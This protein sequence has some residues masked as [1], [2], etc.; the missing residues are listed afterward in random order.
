VIGVL[1]R[2]QLGNHM[3]QYAAARCIAERLGSELVLVSFER[4]NG[5]SSVLRPRFGPLIDGFP[6][7]DVNVWTSGLHRLRPVSTAA[8]RRLVNRLLPLRFSLPNKIGSGN[9]DDRDIEDFFAVTAG[10]LLDGYFQSERF[11]SHR[12]DDVRQWFQPSRAIAERATALTAGVPGG[13]QGALAVHV[14]LGD[15]KEQALWHDDRAYPWVLGREFYARALEQFPP[16]IPLALFSDEPALAARIL[17]RKPTWVASD[18]GPVETLIALSRF[19][20]LVVA[21]SS[22]SWWAGWLGDPGKKVVAPEYHIGRNAGLWC[23][24]GIRTEGWIYV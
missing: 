2:G 16:D 8:H 11:F 22:F 14:R 6:R 4:G 9:L 1:L 24:A 18:A 21:N 17:P 7:V 23:P 10:S 12:A 19:S 20:N 3:F 13:L 5:L 15:Y